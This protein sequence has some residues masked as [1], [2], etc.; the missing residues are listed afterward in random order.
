MKHINYHYTI[1]PATHGINMGIEI[2]HH[3]VCSMTI[4]INA[5]DEQAIEK[6]YTFSQFLTF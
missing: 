5:I 4:M 6:L 3:C 2:C 1:L